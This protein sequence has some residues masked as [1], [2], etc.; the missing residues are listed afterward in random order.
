V[1]G[2]D[3]NEQAKLV[4]KWLFEKMLNEVKSSKKADYTPPEGAVDV[5]NLALSES[6][7]IFLK[8]HEGVITHV[9]NDAKGGS[10]KYCNE[11]N[12]HTSSDWFCTKN[13]HY[14]KD[15]K[16]NQILGKPTIGLGHLIKSQEELDKYCGIKEKIQLS[17]ED[18]W[19]LFTEVDLPK[20]ETPLK[21]AID[22]PI[23]QTQYDALLSFVFNTG[24][25][26]LRNRGVFKNINNGKA[27]S[28]NMEKALMQ[29]KKPPIVIPRREDEINLFNN[30]KYTFNGNEIKI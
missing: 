2:T 28:I 10:S 6:G 5:N 22:V 26:N 16:G 4:E 20:Y 1:I 8:K 29:W 15:K 11:H 9:Y 18:C 17:F 21:K 13:N 14:K 30:G 25:S 27:T 23:T 3:D 24:T 7:I 12:K 19:I